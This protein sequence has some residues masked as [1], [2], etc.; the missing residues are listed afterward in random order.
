MSTCFCGFSNSVASF[1]DRIYDGSM[2]LSVVLPVLNEET[3]VEPLVT[4]ISAAL[5]PSGIEYEVVFVDDGSTDRTVPNLIEM[6]RKGYPVKI[7]VL[8]AHRGQHGAVLAGLSVAGGRFI[9]V[10]D[11]DLQDPPEEIPRF[12][13]GLKDGA[14]LVDGYRLTRD[15]SFARKLSSKLI[16]IIAVIGGADHARDLGC[17]F[18]G[19]SRNPVSILLGSKRPVRYIPAAFSGAKSPGGAPLKHKTIEYSQEP[20]S[21]FGSKYRITSLVK[22]LADM[23]YEFDGIAKL[24]IFGAGAFFVFTKLA[25]Q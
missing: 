21:G 2:E 15:A 23:I 17:M 3:N 4:R 13:E 8:K 11:A 10:L 16:N 5:D 9:I 12:L 25:G 22:L 6:R 20:R 7:A 19:F 18:R 1:R 14:D 24:R